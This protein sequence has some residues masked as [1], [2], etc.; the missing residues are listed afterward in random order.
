MG[1]Q[2]SFTAEVKTREIY[3]AEKYSKRAAE[4]EFGINELSRTIKSMKA[5]CGPEF[6]EIE[7]LLLKR[8]F[9]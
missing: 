1:K 6:P 4:R 3:F 8:K 9:S 5:F 7:E 2:S